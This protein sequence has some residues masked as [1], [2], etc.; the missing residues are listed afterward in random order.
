MIAYLEGPLRILEPS[1]A[2]V[3]AGGVGYD[4]HISLS[5]YYRLEG[6]GT[7]ALEIYTHV[8]EDALSLYGFATADE[9]VAFEKLISITGIGPTLAVKILSGIDPADLADAVQRG[10]ARKLSSIP[11]VG[12]K[13]AERIC[14]ELRDKLVAGLAAAPAAP[15]RHSVDDDVASALTN[16][17]YRPKDAETAISTA[18][19]DLGADAD[20]STLLKRALRH[21]TRG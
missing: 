18:R 21:L 3:L 5:T 2:V 19:Q 13:T 1:R 9:K 4:V 12:K 6:K 11:G 7:A 15:T 8:R 14:L 16:L 10:D 17:G 20:F